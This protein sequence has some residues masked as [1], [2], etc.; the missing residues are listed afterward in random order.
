MTSFRCL[1]LAALFLLAAIHPATAQA[2]ADD[3]AKVVAE[4]NARRQAIAAVKYDLRYE[5]APHIPKPGYPKPGD[6][7][8][9]T[10]TGSV[11]FDMANG[12]L[13]VDQDHFLYSDRPDWV[14]R[15]RSSTRY[16]GQEQTSF[17]TSDPDASKSS[18]E[19]VVR[20]VDIGP[21]EQS[22][23]P[24]P[25]ELSPLL[26]GHGVCWSHRDTDSRAF[27]LAG[28]ADPGRYT[29]LPPEA[30]DGRACVVLRDNAAPEGMTETFWVDAARGGA[31]VRH[32][33]T[34]KNGWAQETVVTY[35][36]GPHGWLPSG[37]VI[38]EIRPGKPPVERY[39]VS[40]AGV[41]FSPTMTAETFR[42]ALKPGT[43]VFTGS[44]VYMV[45]EDGSLLPPDQPPTFLARV[46]SAIAAVG[47]IVAV[48]LGAAVVL[49]VVLIRLRRR[50]V[51]PVVG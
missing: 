31:I 2:P 40:V 9:F 21:W 41:N 51:T 39:R 48:G 33:N 24:W 3:V 27:P 45:G 18:P 46:S 42:V 25:V 36:E 11:T 20:S 43:K 38:R 23:S 26:W 1:L 49:V 10:G 19:P 29:L 4:W 14:S 28:A 5:W 15:V 8:A 16:D 35:Q 50:R 12:R 44:H 22:A 47:G 34:Q 32:R 6:G 37:W 30:V 13:C 17:V 7:R